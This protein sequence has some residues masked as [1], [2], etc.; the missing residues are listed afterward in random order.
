[1]KILIIGSTPRSMVNFRGALIREMME[2]GHSVEA[3]APEMHVDVESA[4]QLRAMGVTTHDIPLQRTGMNP[5]ADLRSLFALR[6]LMRRIRPDLLLSYTIKPVIWGLLAASTARVPQRF[7]LIAGLGYAFGD[8]DGKKR[9]AQQ[10]AQKLYKI[11]ISRANKVFFQNPDDE[12]V[13]RTEGLLPNSVPSVVVNGSGVDIDHFAASRFIDGPPAFVM[14]TRLVGD[15]G[16][17]E[18]AAAAREIK[19][20]YPMVEFHLVGGFDVNP[21]KITEREIAD[22]ESSGILRH[23]GE[24]ADVRPR[25]AAAHICVLP[26]YY[27]EGTPRSLLE[28]MAMGR[29]LITTDAPGC[30]ETVEEGENGFLVPPRSVDALTEAM[31]RFIESPE[32]IAQM[33]RRSREIA[34]EKYDVRKVNAVMLKEMGLKAL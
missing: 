29:P 31:L 15:K 12:E 28:G 3:A 16:I 19:A 25:I 34:E 10:A 14:I 32:L 8:A 30:R 9:I 24:L 7:A 20:R 18:Y 5:I 26:S 23:H 2:S 17:R 1:M 27:R 6:G 33:G 4:R 13:F 22:W 11:A 21:D